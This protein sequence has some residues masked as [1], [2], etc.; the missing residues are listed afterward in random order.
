MN[1]RRTI[2]AAAIAVLALPTAFG[3]AQAQIIYDDGYDR[4]PVRVDEPRPIGPRVYGYY[5]DVEPAP[6]IE[7]ERPSGP[8]GCGEFFFWNGDRCVDARNKPL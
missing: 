6:R 2:L 4:P 5:E 7:L 1:M 8:G 3:S